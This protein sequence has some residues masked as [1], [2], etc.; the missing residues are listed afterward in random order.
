MPVPW[1]THEEYVALH[2]VRP[3]VVSAFATVRPLDCPVQRDLCD[4]ARETCPRFGG[5]EVREPVDIVLCRNTMRWP[6]P[7]PTA[8]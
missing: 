3:C 4:S 7:L 1:D 2:D 8:G 6:L 5:A